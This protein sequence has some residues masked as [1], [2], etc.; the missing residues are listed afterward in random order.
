M[1]LPVSWN[2]SLVVGCSTSKDAACKA[3]LPIQ[4]PYKDQ[5][6]LMGCPVH[7][8]GRGAGGCVGVLGGSC[9]GLPWE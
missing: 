1:M 3:C 9:A 8:G 6:S 2:G 5:K 7:G 4:V